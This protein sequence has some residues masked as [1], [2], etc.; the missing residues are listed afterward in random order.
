M[1]TYPHLFQKLFASP[2]CVLPSTRRALEQALL[3]RMGVV[4]AL[5]RAE[6][7]PVS[8]QG[9]AQTDSQKRR[10]NAIM[11]TYGP[12]AIIHVD[13]VVDKA[14][15]DADMDCYGGLDLND[16]NNALAS[17]AAA[18]RKYSHLVMAYNSPGGSATGVSET[19]QR[20]A[21][22]RDTLEVHSFTDTLCCSAAY[23]LAS[24]ADVIAAS[25]SSTVGS[26]GV[27]MALLD[28]TKALE[29]EGYKVELIK[30]GTFK[31]M[32]ASF[33]P[34]EPDERAMLQDSVLQ[35]HAEF[36]AACTALRPG[37]SDAS[38]QGQWM[39]G[40]DGAKAK[41]VDQ[42]TSLSL[43]EYVASLLSQ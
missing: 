6:D 36:K 12:V 14:I 19:A 4:T 32:G 27:Y 21:A 25:G 26:I 18:G 29:M 35:L 20:I 11:E 13:G 24:Q 22:L 9:A 38:M 42:V 5:P 37:I 3:A 7:P 2:L 16:V 40:A 31:A 23:W 43:D 41:L 28:E 8:A 33:K 34:L 39:S 17:V 10:A 1:K 15:S 30:A